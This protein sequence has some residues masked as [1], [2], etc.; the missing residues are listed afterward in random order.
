M[1]AFGAI[2]LRL[3]SF[4]T[5]SKMYMRKY[6]NLIS[7]F[8]LVLASGFTAC[9]DGDNDYIPPAIEPDKPTT[10]TEPE[11]PTGPGHDWQVHKDGDPY[12]TYM[13]LVMCGYQGWFGTPGDGSQMT[14]NWNE[15]WYHYRESEQFG[16]GVLR[17]SIDFWPDMSEY[18]KQYMPGEKFPDKSGNLH[19]FYGS[20]FTYPDGQ[21][22]TVFSSYDESTV[23]LHF[24]W[25]KEYN[26]SGA[27]MQRFVGEVYNTGQGVPN[28]EHKDHFDVVLKHAMKGSNQ[29][30]RAIAIMYD[31]SGIVTPNALA[32]MVKDAKD[33]MAE[34]QLKDRS[35]Q[36]YYLHENG[37]PLL[38][39]WGVGL[40]DDGHPKP[41]VLDPIVDELKDMG[42]S[43]MLGC[44]A[45]WRQGG[46]DC[47]G[48]QE[49][50]KLIDLI[51]KCDAFIPWYVGRYGYDNF[52]SAE[53]QSRIKEDI[54]TAKT[55]S[56]EDHKVV[57]APHVFP[58]GSDRNMH[59]NNGYPDGD[60][61][62]TGYRYGG[63]FF[64]Q[65]LYLDIKNGA[66][67]LYIGM[68]DEMDEGTAIFK[69]LNVSDV[70]SNEYQGKDYYVNFK[71]DGGYSITS[72]EMTKDVQ[73]SRL[74]SELDIRF[75]GIDDNLPTDYYLYLT[76]EANK[77]LN[78][79]GNYS[80]NQP[81]K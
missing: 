24:K 3:S 31:M 68:F 5:K 46:N 49:H 73:W 17:N 19:N 41:S 75:Q 23:L 52:S 25:M 56:T 71:S 38:A 44:P 13:G 34:Y 8:C 33:L 66:Q 45:Y 2:H 15:G 67:A 30:Q 7:L 14:K 64:W 69:Q 72:T 10:P 57:Y 79:L 80:E 39:L 78:G 40:N 16:P 1:A 61:S 43:I 74:A 28:T 36:K 11:T 65:Q 37:K 35:V 81:R 27:F 60:K 9:G 55:Y 48:G 54:A 58:G 29:Y 63:K 51:K 76:G 18:E 53:W 70:P 32:C 50:T 22:A 47:V 42:W 62:Q 20:P 77:M 4:L 59:P 12:D 21:Q 26:I 6:K